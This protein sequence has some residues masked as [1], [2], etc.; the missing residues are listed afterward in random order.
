MK[1]IIVFISISV[2]FFFVSCNQDD[3][4][5]VSNPDSQFVIKFQTEPLLLTHGFFDEDTKAESWENELNSLQ[6]F[7][8]EGDKSQIIST[9]YF[10]ESELQSGEKYIS[11]DEE[12][13]GKN[14]TFYAYGNAGK[15]D[16][17]SLPNLVSSARSRH[18]GTY[19]GTFN[20]VLQGEIFDSG[21]EMSAITKAT[22]SN[23][24]S[25]TEV[26]LRLERITNKI[27]I[28]TKLSDTFRE[29]YDGGDLRI[30]SVN[31][32]NGCS[33]SYLTDQTSAL[34]GSRSAVRQEPV[35]KDGYYQNLL[36]AFE[37]SGS[38]LTISIDATFDEDGDFST[39]HDQKEVT[40]T[41]KT[42]AGY[43]N[44]YL[45]KSGRNE[46][47]RINVIIQGLPE[48]IQS[49]AIVEENWKDAVDEDNSLGN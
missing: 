14:L 20:D 6:V 11:M 42:M 46:Y 10:S 48:N 40:Y 27:A 1:Q 39:T 34:N 2:F 18:I 13:L 37:T 38:Q 17:V 5:E 25:I 24:G 45:K 32:D 31:I 29:F 43:K 22:K 4:P 21:F 26:P 8:F 16:P 33:L 47:Y 44:S 7:I 36:Y 49:L 23:D 3:M 28:K 15:L 30:N 41:F 35:Y 9:F 19:N 12:Y